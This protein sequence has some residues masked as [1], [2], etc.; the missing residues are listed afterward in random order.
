LSSYLI[1]ANKIVSM[2]IKSVLGKRESSRD[3]FPRFTPSAIK[4]K[5]VADGE[6]LGSSQGGESRSPP[7]GFWVLVT[8]RER[9]QRQ[10]KVR[11]WVEGFFAGHP[12]G[13][14]RLV[15]REHGILDKHTLY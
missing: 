9:I 15:K 7:Q 2:E 12:R 5:G 1:F 8:T 10:G 6:G 3:P 14:C 11:G 13:K 4:S